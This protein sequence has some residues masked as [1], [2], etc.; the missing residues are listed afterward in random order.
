MLQT[1]NVVENQYLMD[2]QIVLPFLCTLRLLFLKKKTNKL[3]MVNVQITIYKQIIQYSP[4]IKHSSIGTFL[5]LGSP[6]TLAI[7]INLDD[8]H[9]EVRLSP[10]SSPK[11]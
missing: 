8:F 3:R 11:A 9:Q 7:S 2:G 4:C 6:T 10:M 5:R 1:R